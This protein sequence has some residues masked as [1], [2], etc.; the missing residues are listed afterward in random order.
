MHLNRF[1]LG[2]CPKPCWGSLQRSPDPLAVFKGPTSKG[3]EGKGEERR[4]R[5]AGGKG[6]GR[7]RGRTT[8]H[9]P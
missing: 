9:T 2:L 3:K 5:E 1:W 7:G 4:E 8:L 6:E